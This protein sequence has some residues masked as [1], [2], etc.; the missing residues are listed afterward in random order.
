MR[1]DP[2]MWRTVLFSLGVVTF[3][4]GVYQ[5]LVENNPK[6]PA[7]SLQRNYWLFMLSLGCIMYYRYLKQRD[8][9]A[10]FLADPKNAPKVQ[11]KTPA[12]SGKPQPR[13]KP[14]K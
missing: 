12:K 6:V 9:E 3:V 5:T 14:R 2:S 7:E 10:R 4:I 11:P 13:K 8:K 1:I